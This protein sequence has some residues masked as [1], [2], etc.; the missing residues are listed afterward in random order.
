MA[1]AAEIDRI[2]LRL[3]EAEQ[4]GAP[5]APPSRA[6]EL[7][8]RDAY[9]VQLRNVE[10]HETAGRRLVG[11]KVGLTSRAMQEALGVDQ[12]DFGHLFEDMLLENGG[13]VDR[14]RFIE[15]RVEPEIAFTMSADLIGPGIGPDDVRAAVASAHPAL[16][17]IDSRVANWEIGLLDTVA[18]NASCGAVVIGEPAE[19]EEVDLAAVECRLLV[20]GAVVETGLGSAVLGHPFAAVAWLA[21]TLSELETPVR[22]GDLVLP[23]SCTR[24]VPLE[25]G[26]RAEADFGVLG[27]VSIAVE[28]GS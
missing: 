14:G 18:D 26:T 5:I 10:R 9:A 20:D 13:A 24:A 8:L 17:V 11:K 27:T 22:A 15:P 6:T 28:E 1:S 23:G 7:E 12:P 25:T 4:T 16:E 19:W 2:A 21:N 3:F